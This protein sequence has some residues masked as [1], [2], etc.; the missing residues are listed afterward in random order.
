MLLV[1]ISKLLPFLD[2]YVFQT[3][4]IML[5]MLWARA[6][7]KTHHAHSFSFIVCSDWSAY[8][9]LSQHRTPYL[10]S[11]LLHFQ[12]Q[13]SFNS[14][15]NIGFNFT[16]MLHG[17]VMGCHKV[18]VIQVGL[19]TRCLRLFRNSVS[20]GRKEL[21]SLQTLAFLVFKTFCMHKNL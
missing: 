10:R 14:S 1:Q 12:L 2:Y 9:R 21:L 3:L 17:D 11:A 4:H 5:F 19:L 8:T 16:N 6:S 15:V 7:K 13:V 20:C 18:T